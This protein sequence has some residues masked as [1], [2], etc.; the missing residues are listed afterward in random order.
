MTIMSPGFNSPKSWGVLTGFISAVA[1]P[2]AVPFSC[3]AELK[4]MTVTATAASAMLRSL[5]MRRFVVFIFLI[6]R[7]GLLS[8]CCP[9]PGAAGRNASG[10]LLL[11]L[12]TFGRAAARLG[13]AAEGGV[14]TARPAT[15][16]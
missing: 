6:F 3:A 15:V 1:P 5:L 11:L 2:L 10:L 12:H 16:L 13:G 4:D 14:I 7:F 9:R 8:F